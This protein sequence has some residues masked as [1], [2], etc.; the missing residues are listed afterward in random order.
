MFNTVDDVLKELDEIREALHAA[1]LPEYV[2]D[3]LERYRDM[4]L[5]LPIRK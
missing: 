3:M 2:S 5:R 4:L 1:N